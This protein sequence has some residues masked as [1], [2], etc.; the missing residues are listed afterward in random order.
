[1]KD[2][3]LGHV[4][5]FSMV[6]QKHEALVASQELHKTQLEEL[7]K[8]ITQKMELLEE[9]MTSMSSFVLVLQNEKGNI[10]RDELE[11][12]A[13]DIPEKVEQALTD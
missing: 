2:E 12:T 5:R 1:M 6:K 13:V 9:R 4:E 7:G 8:L 3:T 11:S 10:V